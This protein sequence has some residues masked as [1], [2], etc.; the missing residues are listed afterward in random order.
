MSRRWIVVAGFSLLPGCIQVKWYPLYEDESAAEIPTSVEDL[1]ERAKRPP[2]GVTRHFMR[3]YPPDGVET[4]SRI[5]SPWLRVLMFPVNLIPNMT[6]NAIAGLVRPFKGGCLCSLLGDLLDGLLCFGPR[7]SWHGYPFW[8][9]TE[10]D[11][12]SWDGAGSL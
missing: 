2:R 9:P 5:E 11:P 8:E 12:S 3:Q 7:D 4:R 10:L 6:S 1:M